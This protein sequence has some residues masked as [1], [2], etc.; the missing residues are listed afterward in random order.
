MQLD[1]YEEI[2]IEEAKN[3]ED[4]DQYIKFD[5]N[6][7]KNISSPLLLNT[8][9]VNLNNAHNLQGPLTNGRQSSENKHE[10]GN[11][12]FHSG[13]SVHQDDSLSNSQHNNKQISTPSRQALER[14]PGTPNLMI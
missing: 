7:D 1:T 11:S 13:K 12:F 8:D 6:A 2:P 9:F 4:Q 5:E 10:N 3:K 14:T